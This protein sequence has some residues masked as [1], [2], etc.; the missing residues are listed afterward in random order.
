MINQTKI[1]IPVAAGELIDKITILRL[2]FNRLQNPK[3]L[4]NVQKEL[5]AL[6]SVYQDVILI[7]PSP[8]LTKLSAE[9]QTV[10]T[11]LWDVEDQLRLLESEKCFNEDFI[12]LARSVYR[13]NDLRAMVKRRINELCDSDLTEEK[14]Y[15][16]QESP[17]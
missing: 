13:L 4:S 3:A 16:N 12:A 15:C 11:Q 10:N 9:L 5:N 6:E 7:I 2:K 17:E 14:S 1:V 8:E